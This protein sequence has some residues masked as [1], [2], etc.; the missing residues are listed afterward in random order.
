MA[1]REW[2]DPNLRECWEILKNIKDYNN[3]SFER[4]FQKIY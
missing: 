1:L 2:W 3:Q 4:K